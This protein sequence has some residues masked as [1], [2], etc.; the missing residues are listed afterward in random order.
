MLAFALLPAPLSAQPRGKPIVA[1]YQMD[2]VAGSGQAPAFSTMIET[3]IASTSKFRVIERE[4]LNTLV[5]EQAR[6]KSG[7]VRTNRPG[8]MG[9]FEGADYLIYGSITS[10]SMANKTNFGA[11]LLGGVLSGS[12]NSNV[13]CN[14]SY[15]TLGVDIKITDANSGEVKY[16]TRINETKKSA[17]VCNGNAQVDTGALLRSAAEKIATALVTT[18]YPIQIAAVQGD[19]TI[20]LNY[21]E[22]TVQPGQVYGIYAK[23]SAIIDPATGEMIGN[24]EQKLGFI[25]ITDVTG[26]ISRA[27][28]HVP[29]TTP[30]AVGA[31]ARPASAG[32][33]QALN[34]K[35]KK[36]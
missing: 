19:G 24:D 1:I 5:G 25:R 13:T 16:V 28:A 23:G 32:D 29:F 18:I 36:R 31:I 17:A 2:D 21:G 7:L 8:K 9:G 12:N 3:A 35:K 22:G 30:P 20:V 14:N 11:S 33:L 15:V 6:A 27:V 26:R 10:V 34:G 4:R